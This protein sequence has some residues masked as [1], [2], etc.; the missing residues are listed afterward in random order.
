ME[1]E[2][3]TSKMSFLEVQQNNTLDWKTNY[4]M[5]HY[6]LRVIDERIM[7]EIRIL[8]LC[9]KKSILVDICRQSLVNAFLFWFCFKR[10]G[11]CSCMTFFCYHQVMDW[12]KKFT[13]HSR[14]Y[15]CWAAFLLQ[16]LTLS[17]LD[18]MH[19]NFYTA[20]LSLLKLIK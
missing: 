3:P 17:I 1:F 6:S 8:N 19:N 7:S 13:R 11:K 12:W 20:P 15:S 9:H 10:K 18:C 4:S 5:F 16:P 14:G 2:L